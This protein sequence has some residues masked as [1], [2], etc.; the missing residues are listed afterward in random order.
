MLNLY[1]GCNPRMSKVIILPL[2]LMI[3]LLILILFPLHFLPDLHVSALGSG[4]STIV[5]SRLP[6]FN[7]YVN[8]IYGFSIDYPNFWQEVEFNRDNL[9]VSFVSNS[10]NESSL[11]ENVAL[12]V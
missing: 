6:K 1:Q 9:I 8:T 5:E 7:T 3:L 11:L 2:I 10:V 4:E 12:Q